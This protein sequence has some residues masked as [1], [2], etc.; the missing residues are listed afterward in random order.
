VLT[1]TAMLLATRIG[2]I[3]L[4]AKGYGYLAWVIIAVYAIP[5]ATVGAWRIFAY[6]KGQRAPRAIL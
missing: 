1:L 3:D 5:L 4:I 6:D 2:L